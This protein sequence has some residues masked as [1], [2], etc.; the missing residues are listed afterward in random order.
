MDFVNKQRKETIQLKTKTII[1]LLIVFPMYVLAQFD[2]GYESFSPN[3]VDTRSISMGRTSIVSA[4]GSNSI[5]SNPGIIATLDSRQGQAGGRMI[6]GTVEDEWAEDYYYSY[7]SKLTP[8]FSINHISVSIPY[9]ITGSDMNLAVGIGY[10]TYFDWGMSKETVIEYDYENW[11]IDKITSESTQNGGLNVITPTIAINLQNKY[12]VGATFNKSISGTIEYELQLNYE[13]SGSDYKDEIEIEHSASFLNFGGL[14]KV[15]EQLTL[16]FS[17]TP[18]FEW[19]WD[20]I[21][22]TEDGERYTDDGV[23]IEIPSVMG[24]GA[25]Y[26][27]SPTLLIAG[28]YQN[29]KFSDIELGNESTGIDD[30]VCYRIGAEFQGLALL[31]IGCFSDAVLAVDYDD[32]DPKSLTGFTGGIGY[33]LGSIYLDAYAEYSSITTKNENYDYDDEEEINYVYDD[34][35][36][37][38]KFGL[39]VNYKFK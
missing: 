24:I 14:A 12:F 27:F 23:D 21:K 5:F 8:H 33:E 4:T 30:G 39:S 28:E 2:Y 22:Y 16:G 38:F 25:T 29:R 6:M 32:D 3:T 35:M 7:D 34:S 17:F 11:N 10:R 15:N 18:A 20:E 13:D 19:E 1:M 26:Q 37:M 36:K 9:K 31:R